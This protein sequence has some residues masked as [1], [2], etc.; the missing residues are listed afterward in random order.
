MIWVTIGLFLLLVVCIFRLH[1]YRKQIK[2][3]GKD[4]QFIRQKESNLRITQEI[5]YSEINQLVNQ[6]NQLIQRHRELEKEV[7]HK[8]YTLKNLITNISHD[9]R[10]PLTSLDGY[11]ELLKTCENENDKQRYYQIINGRIDC[12]K[13]LLEQ[14]F[15]YMKLQNASYEMEMSKCNII[16]IL[17]SSIFGFYQN[18]TERN[19]EPIISLPETVIL[20]NGNESGLCRVFQN[21]IK[22]VLEHG[23]DKFTLTAVQEGE[24]V[25]IEFCNQFNEVTSIDMDQVFDRFYKADQAR[26]NSSTGLG[27]AITKE[28][29][30]MMNGT[31]KATL[32]D[33]EFKI[34][35]TFK[36]MK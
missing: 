16:K 19:M 24:K 30:E 22:N 21:V 15:L 20:V 17:Y 7:Y 5:R 12:L 8:E 25:R 6:L 36:T 3:L 34:T 26:S 18:F 1:L 4:L 32:E 27:L 35:I 11:F 2:N 14:L 29:V 10:T 9:I 28:L 23:K 33:R 13:D 31:I